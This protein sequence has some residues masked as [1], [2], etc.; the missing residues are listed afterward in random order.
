MPA[1]L[2]V[3]VQPRASRNEVIGFDTDG[4]L[5]VRVTAPPVDGEA[6]RAVIELMAKTLGV[7]KSR[8]RIVRGE[9]SRVKVVE[10]DGLNGAE[11]RTGITGT[12][13]DRRG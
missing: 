11:V 5:K 2:T 12:D 4:A 1:R 8:V 6:N 10:V 9:S 3:R 7:A 13:R